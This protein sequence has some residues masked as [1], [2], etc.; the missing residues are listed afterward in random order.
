MQDRIEPV[1]LF[2]AKAATGST[3]AYPIQDMQHVFLTKASTGTSNYTIKVQISNQFAK[4]DFSA[5]ST[6]TNA[7]AYVQVKELITNTAIDGATGF[8]EAGADATRIF[9]VNT[10]GQRWIGATITNY[11]A[12]AIDLVLTAKNNQ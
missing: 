10:N 7:W 3:T 12:G 11:S 2:D 1:K 9:E 8:S 5:A 4:P 6:P